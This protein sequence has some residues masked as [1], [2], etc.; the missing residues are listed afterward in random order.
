MGVGDEIPSTNEGIDPSF[1][2]GLT[3]RRLSRRQMMGAIGAGVA[4]FAAPD[5]SSL[6]GAATTAKVGSSKWWS[7]QKLHRKVDF[8]NWPYYIDVVNGKHLSLEHFTAT[9][10]IQVTYREVIQ[11]NASFY[12][13]IR[14]SLQ[15]G[16]STG[17]DIMVMTNNN[18]E[19]GY[20][21]ESNWLIPLDR[22]KMTNFNKYAGTLVKNPP[23]DPGNKYTM[24]WQSG[25][26]SVAYNSKLVKDPGDSVQIL[27]DKKYAG[28]VGMLS[29]P[30]E[31][32]SVGLLAIGVEPAKSTESDWA[33]A[34]VK[35]QK[36]KSDGIV[37]A[38][39]DQSYIQHLKNGDTVVS[40]C[41]S[42]DIFQANLNS[43]YKDL[44]LMIPKEG[45]MIWTD[46]MIIPVHAANPL[47]AMTC[48]DYFYSPITQ[49]VVEYY[50]DYICPV[51][52]AKEQ[53]LHPTGWN[54]AALK[55]M[56]SEIQL[57]T[58]VT[59]DSLVVFPS[60]ARIKASLPYYPF[61]NQEEITA[62]TNLFLPIIQGA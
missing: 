43:K 9:T 21:I 53:L 18:P 49:S 41:Y 25:W 44:V 17:Y 20:L 29:D 26:T 16:Q 40:Q 51:P 39:Y 5:L 31:L 36:Q 48:M 46:N 19:L 34:A 6:A 62:W 1:F 50:N 22:S 52:D 12:A 59:A 33:K 61:K 8:A 10:G 35:L 56:Y 13:T 11:D 55:E 60:P 38:Y 2:R 37:A 58:S 30:F 15:A 14:P 23:Y 47:D 4:A 24:A 54:K 28:K 45:L 32:G 27:F 7:G 57:P 42:G 3:Q